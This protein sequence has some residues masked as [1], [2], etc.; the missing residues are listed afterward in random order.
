AELRELASKLAEADRM[1]DSFL[2][3]VSH[4]LRTPLNAIAGWSRILRT[5]RGTEQFS[6]AL[7]VIERNAIAQTQLVEDLLDVSRMTTG[8]L[9]LEVQPIDL[10]E[11]VE[12][13]LEAVGLAAEA[14]S[15]RIRP[16]IDARG[17]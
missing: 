15:I 17:S 13:A 2:A 1:K 10:A 6:H 16:T 5:R 14:K 9:A 12:R 3:A 7:D 4:E 11:I 8:K